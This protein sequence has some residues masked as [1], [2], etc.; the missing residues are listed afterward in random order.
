MAETLLKVENLSTEFRTVGGVVHAVD[1]ISFDVRVGETF[2]LV[3]ESA[4]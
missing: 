4:S 2:A 1:D 3:G